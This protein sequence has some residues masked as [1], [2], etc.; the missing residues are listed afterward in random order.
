MFEPLV[1][2]DDELQLAISLPD[3]ISVE[4]G[5]L[6]SPSQLTETTLSTCS[7]DALFVSG[8]LPEQRDELS[9]LCAAKHIELVVFD[10]PSNNAAAIQDVVVN[11]S[12]KLFSDEM[13]NNVDLADI[14]N[15]N[16]SSDYL[17]AFSNKTAA[18]DFMETQSI[19]VVVGGIYLAHAQTDLSEYEATNKALLHHFSEYAF[20]CSSFH[21]AGRSECTILLG[22]KE[23]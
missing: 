9:H 20:L 11:L 7:Y 18:V 10:N 15:L 1:L 6:I 3:L 5:Q 16:Q 12:D 2:E 21:S 19:G 13:P 22:V 17:F 14:R 4:S 23:D 8:L